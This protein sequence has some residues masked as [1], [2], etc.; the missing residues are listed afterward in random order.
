M[1]NELIPLI[2]QLL[3][4]GLWRHWLKL[5][6]VMGKLLWMSASVSQ[7]LTYSLQTTDSQ[8]QWAA[9]VCHHVKLWSRSTYSIATACSPRYWPH[10][11]MTVLPQQLLPYINTHTTIQSSTL[12]L[13]MM[14]CTQQEISFLVR[15]GGPTLIERKTE[16]AHPVP[17]K[18]VLKPNPCYLSLVLPP[19]PFPPFLLLQNL[20]LKDFARTATS[21][22]SGNFNWSHKWLKG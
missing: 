5:I 15:N 8:L 6:N 22:K 13:S 17:T 20:C 7:H 9:R 1:Y 2:F 14:A 21:S 11:H 4:L 3:W 18:A 16:M 10:I 12:L 19:P